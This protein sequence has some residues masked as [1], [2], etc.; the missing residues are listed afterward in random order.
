MILQVLKDSPYL[1]IPSIRLLLYLKEE[2]FSK[3]KICKYFNL[4][5]PGL[6]YQLN[7]MARVELAQLKEKESW[8]ELR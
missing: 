4:P 6:P 5:N 3:G 1:L 2:I 7:Q 8:D